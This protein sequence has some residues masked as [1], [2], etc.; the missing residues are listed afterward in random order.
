LSG[1]IANSYHCESPQYTVKLKGIQERNMSIQKGFQS[2]NEIPFLLTTNNSRILT[3]QTMFILCNEDESI[4][5][6]IAYIDYDSRAKYISKKLCLT[7]TGTNDT[8]CKER[9]K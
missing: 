7:Y 2:Q 9:D 1:G 3:G 4:C 8:L 5:K 6:E